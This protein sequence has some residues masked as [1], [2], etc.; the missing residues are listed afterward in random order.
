VPNAA[1]V[2][3]RNAQVTCRNAEVTCRHARPPSPIHNDTH[4]L[5][6]A[7]GFDGEIYIYVYIYI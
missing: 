5:L 1:Q 2:T 4:L 6:T 3:C 7:V